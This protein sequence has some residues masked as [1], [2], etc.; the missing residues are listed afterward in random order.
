MQIITDIVDSRRL[1]IWT[2]M[3]RRPVCPPFR[4]D[5]QM[6]CNFFA[7]STVFQPY[8]DDG[9]LIMKGHVQWNSVYGRE[10]LT[11]SGIYS[12]R[13]LLILTKMI[14]RPVCLP[15]RM[16]GQMTCNF[17]AFST[18]FQPYQDDGRLIMKGRVQWNS[19]YGRE[20][21]T[22]SGDRTQSA[23]SVGQRLTH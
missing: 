4:M 19:V 5:G 16:D 20:D 6:T 17:F 12:S 15:F 9:R 10:D 23:N 18:V 8:Q 13:R 1:L 7:F 14:R 21:L 2:K 22:S 11:S 3:I